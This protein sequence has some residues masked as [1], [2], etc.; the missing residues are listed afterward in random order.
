LGRTNNEWVKK[1]KMHGTEIVDT[2]DEVAE[3]ESPGADDMSIHQ[4]ESYI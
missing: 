4:F 3:E 2:I 1:L